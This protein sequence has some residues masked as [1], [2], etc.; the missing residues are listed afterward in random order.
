MPTYEYRAVVRDFHTPGGT[1]EIV[2]GCVETL[3]PSKEHASL[4]MIEQI[5]EYHGYAFDAII[6]FELDKIDDEPCE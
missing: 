3:S 5:R 2:S 6:D 1:Q 4:R